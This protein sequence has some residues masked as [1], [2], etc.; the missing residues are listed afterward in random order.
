MFPGHDVRRITPAGNNVT[1]PAFII[2]AG[3]FIGEEI[4]CVRAGSSIGGIIG[5]V[6]PFLIH[7]GGNLTVIVQAE[8]DVNPHVFCVFDDPVQLQGTVH[9]IRVVAQTRIRP[10]DGR[11]PR[12]HPH[13]HEISSGGRQLSHP[14]LIVPGAAVIPPADI[15]TYRKIGL[16]RI[17]LQVSIMILADEPRIF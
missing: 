7:I 12:T 8:H 14:V 2:E 17:I 3:G 15:V 1:N 10:L 5:I 11:R 16:S 4:P 6:V 13:P 9:S